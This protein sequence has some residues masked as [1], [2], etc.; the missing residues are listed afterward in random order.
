[1]YNI[2]DLRRSLQMQK[3]ICGTIIHADTPAQL[4]FYKSPNRYK[5]GTSSIGLSSPIIFPLF[6][7]SQA[8]TAENLGT[9]HR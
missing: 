5:A 9:A 6:Q 4:R 8:K 3:D 2:N 1:M 7:P